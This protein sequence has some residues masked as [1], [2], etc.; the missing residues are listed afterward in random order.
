MARLLNRQ[1]LVVIVSAIAPRKSHRALAREIIG[2]PYRE[3][4]VDAPLCLCEARDAK[5]PYARGLEASFES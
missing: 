3:V 1:G 4:H 5:N 2:A